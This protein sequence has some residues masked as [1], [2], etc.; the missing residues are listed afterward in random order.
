MSKTKSKKRKMIQ[1]K[2]KKLKLIKTKSKK[3]NKKHR[4]Y[5]KK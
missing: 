2:S 3:S 4:S 5:K 1:R